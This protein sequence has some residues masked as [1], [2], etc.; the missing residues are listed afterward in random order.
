MVFHINLQ[1]Q[2]LLHACIIQVHA[3]L[4][5]YMRAFSFKWG[6]RLAMLYAGYPGILQWNTQE[7][8][9][10]RGKAG[11]VA[12]FVINWPYLLFAPGATWKKKDYGLIHQMQ[13]YTLY[14][15]IILT[16]ILSC[17]LQA[18]VNTWD[19][20][21][22]HFHPRFSPSIL[23]FSL[24]IKSFE[25]S[26]GSLWFTVVSFFA[27]RAKQELTGWKWIPW[28]QSKGCGILEQYGEGFFWSFSTGNKA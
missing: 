2:E 7:T 12:M 13:C 25:S 27:H 11:K 16:S 21:V 26:K 20:T 8:G 23:N 9:S 6:S 28:F 17:L 22:G 19:V 24:F 4:H 15:L 14:G 10:E 1:L 3:H 5:I 18:E